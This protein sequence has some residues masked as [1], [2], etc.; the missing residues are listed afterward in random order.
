MLF[1]VERARL[2]KLTSYTELNA[3]MGHLLLILARDLDFRG[4]CGEA[5]GVFPGQAD[6]MD[7]CEFWL[8]RA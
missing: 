4:L 6:G 2:G 8:V 5:F 1:L 7:F 3:R